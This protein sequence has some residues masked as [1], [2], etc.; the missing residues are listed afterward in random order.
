MP[1]YYFFVCVGYQF[2]GGVWGWTSTILIGLFTILMGLSTILI[3]L[4][5][6]YP[7]LC[8]CQFFFERNVHE[9]KLF[10]SSVQVI[11]NDC[12]NCYGI[13]MHRAAKLL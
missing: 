8:C 13:E 3:G 5:T 1:L 4:S 12:I 10:L 6:G 9:L 7:R 2:R 11:S